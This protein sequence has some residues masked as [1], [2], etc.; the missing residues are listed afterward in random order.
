MGQIMGSLNA[1]DVG[2]IM[3]DK[4]T[5]DPQAG[6]D[7][8]RKQRGIYLKYASKISTFCTTDRIFIY[9]ILSY[10]FKWYF[11]YYIIVFFRLYSSN[12]LLVITVMPVSEDALISAKIPPKYRDFCADHL[13]EYQICRYNKMPLL[14]KCAHEKHNYLNC[15]QQE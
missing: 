5:F 2:L 12:S 7:F 6:F 10:Y 13:L 9:S 1:R 8:E 15:E 4:P 14:Y 3:D 11:C